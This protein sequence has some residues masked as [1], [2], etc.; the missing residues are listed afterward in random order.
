MKI[1][2]VISGLGTG[3]AEKVLTL[4]A[5][6]FFS[7]EYDVNILKFNDTTPFFYLEPKINIYSMEKNFNKLQAIKK[8]KSLQA[9]FQGISPDIIISFTTTVNIY[10]IIAAKIL[11]LPIIVSEHTNYHR[12][13]NLIW[14]YL[15]R[16]SYPFANKVVLLTEYDKKQYTFLKQKVVIRNPLVLTNQHQNVQ[17]DKLI[18]AVGRLHKVKGFDLL[19]EAF[20]NINNTSWKLEILGDG[21]E[22][23][24]LQEQIKKLNLSHRVKLLGAKKDIELYYKRASIFVLSSRAEGF[25]GSLCEAMGYGCPSIAFNCISGPNEIITHKQ[26]GILVQPN[27]IQELIYA[28]NYLIKNKKIRKKFEKNSTILNKKL[29]LEKISTIWLTEIKSILSND[30]LI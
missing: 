2:F 15:R 1:L 18:L 7:K 27:N 16:V 24:N 4:L 11:R 30:P 28:L 3:G 17:K 19:I 21:E 9:K 10:S 25:P 14:K 13:K 8:I 5:N 20:A 26:N 12:T 6:N 22:Y 23:T 29:N